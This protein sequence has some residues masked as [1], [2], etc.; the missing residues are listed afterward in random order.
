MNALRAA[1]RE[2][3][4]PTITRVPE[5]RG[6]LEER[7]NWATHAVGVLLSMVACYLI[8][9][10]TVGA[11]M[12]FRV[13]CVVY[14][15]SLLL[16]YS[17]SATYHACGSECW[18][19][20]LRT[21][22]HICIYYLIAG[23]YTPFMLSWMRGP[24]GYTLLAV[25]W[26]LAAIGTL[27]KLL[28]KARFDGVSAIAY[29]LMGWCILPVIGTMLHTCPIGSVVWMLIGGF[30]YTGG[31]IFYRLDHYLPYFHAV[32]HVFVLAGS[33]AQFVAIYVY[34]VPWRPV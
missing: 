23:S 21:F 16:V 11:L 34:V 17:S 15:F 22:D 7:L 18:K 29:V 30:F 3:I 6:P 2:L 5:P 9:R 28:H 24:V 10:G 33:I 14:A 12:S 31:V 19:P 25:V 4:T 32:W 13:G 26:S 1:F 27:F 8:V 20:R